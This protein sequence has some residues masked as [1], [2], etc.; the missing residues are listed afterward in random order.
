MKILKFVLVLFISISI[1]SCSSESKEAPFT[2]SDANIVGTYN[3]S[4]FSAEEVESATS[5][6][7]VTVELSK[8]TKIGDTFQVSLVMNANGTFVATG[9]YRSVS[10]VIPTPNAGQANPAIIV[11][12]SSGS[13]LLNTALNTISFTQKSGDFIDGSFDI[14]TFNESKVVIIQETIDTQG[15][16]TNE[17]KTSITFNRE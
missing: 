15:G 6:A 11:L 2:L 4:S 3:I 1:T 17:I 8:N 12:N 13:Y 7:G 10:T 16:I 14:T 9:E 5:S